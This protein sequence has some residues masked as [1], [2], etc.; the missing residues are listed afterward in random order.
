[1]CV[2]V[3]IYVFW[4]SEEKIFFDTRFFKLEAKRG[5]LNDF[6]RVVGTQTCSESVYSFTKNE[7]TSI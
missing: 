2:C 5:A 4:Y 1:M 6:D 7:L 3:S